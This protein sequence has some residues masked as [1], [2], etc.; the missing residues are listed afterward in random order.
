MQDLMFEPATRTEPD[1]SPPTRAFIASTPAERYI[2]LRTED[3]IAILAFLCEICM[4][5]RVVR[6]HIDWGDASLTELRKE[7]IEVN[8][9]KRRLYVVT[10]HLFDSSLLV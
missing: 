4:A 2:Y 3:K 8:R 7:K 9:E 5:S 10:Y 1:S 6:A